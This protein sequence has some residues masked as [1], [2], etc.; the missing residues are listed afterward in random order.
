MFVETVKIHRDESNELKSLEIRMGD[1]RFFEAKERII[2]KGYCLIVRDGTKLKVLLI[3]NPRACKYPRDWLNSLEFKILLEGQ[4]LHLI[5]GGCWLMQAYSMYRFNNEPMAYKWLV[6]INNLETQI[7][8]YS[9]K[10]DTLPSV[11]KISFYG[12]RLVSAMAIFD[13]SRLREF[14]TRCLACYSYPDYDEHYKDT[15]TDD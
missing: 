8:S 7:S 14:F 9:V 12:K 10:K 4:D 5:Y 15:P 6:S 1:K 11:N 2:K 13:S 3:D